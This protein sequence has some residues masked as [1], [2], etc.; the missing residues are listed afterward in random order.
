MTK[1]IIV[2]DICKE[3]RQKFEHSHP[4]NGPQTFSAR[5][6]RG[7]KT[8]TEIDLCKKCFTRIQGSGVA[9]LVKED[10]VYA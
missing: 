5:L 7:G 1:T 3:K 8:A 10:R 2:C 9:Q 4:S 6:S